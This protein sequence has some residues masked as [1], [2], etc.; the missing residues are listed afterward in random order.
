MNGQFRKH[1]P[2]FGYQ[3][4]A[5]T[6]VSSNIGSIL[7]N[8][9]V[10]AVESFPWMGVTI[11]FAMASFGSWVVKQ[12]FVDSFDVGVDKKCDDWFLAKVGVTLDSTLKS[13]SV[14]ERMLT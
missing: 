7:S 13:K 10:W 9:K 5:G 3:F 4:S 2:T 14:G 11:F 8:L 12:I 1:E 6:F